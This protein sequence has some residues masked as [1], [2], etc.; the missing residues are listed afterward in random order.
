MKDFKNDLKG[1]NNLAQMLISDPK[2]VLIYVIKFHLFL[3][4]EK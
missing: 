3:F 1:A 4:F 2:G